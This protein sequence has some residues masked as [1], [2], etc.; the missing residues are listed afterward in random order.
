MIIV[1]INSHKLGLHF[2]LAVQQA[3]CGDISRVWLCEEGFLLI[4]LTGAGLTNKV[5]GNGKESLHN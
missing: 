1:G 3:F 4:G 2:I 5:V